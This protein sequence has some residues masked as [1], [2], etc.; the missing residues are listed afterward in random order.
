M[1]FLID[2]IVKYLVSALSFKDNLLGANG[3]FKAVGLSLADN[4]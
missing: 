1:T 3:I 2:N 4:H